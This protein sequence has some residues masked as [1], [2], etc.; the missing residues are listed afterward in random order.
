VEECSQSAK[1]L[2]AAL[3]IKSQKKTRKN[4][5]KNESHFF[6]V[7]CGDWVYGIEDV[8]QCEYH[9]LV[10]LQFYTHVPL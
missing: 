2:Q 10:M 5:Q 7:R 8:L 1:S 6:Q 3:V 4:L 9:A